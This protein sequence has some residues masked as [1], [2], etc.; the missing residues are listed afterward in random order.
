MKFVMLMFLGSMLVD[1]A[2]KQLSPVTNTHP[3]APPSTNL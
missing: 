3:V 1:F 2:F